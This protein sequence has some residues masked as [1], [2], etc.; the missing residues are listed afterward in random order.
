MASTDPLSIV[1]LSRAIS[2]LTEDFFNESNK[3][4]YENYIGLEK[5]ISEFLRLK[6]PKASEILEPAPGPGL[7]A[8]RLQTKGFARIDALENC[9]ENIKRLAKTG[10]YRTLIPRPVSRLNSTG[11]KDDIYDVVAMV[12]GFNPEK[13]YPKAI[14]ELLRITKPD[15]HILWT[16]RADLHAHQ[17][18]YS[19]LDE[20]LASLEK[21]G[22]CV[23]VKMAEK[24][25]DLHS[26]LQGLLYV[27]RRVDNEDFAMEIPATIPSLVVDSVKDDSV[28]DLLQ[29]Q[30]FEEWSD[31]SEEDLVMVGQYT[32]H[33]KLCKAFL[34]LNLPRKVE[35]LDVSSHSS[36]P[37]LVGMEL[38]HHGYINVDGVDHKL[39]ALNQIRRK[40]RI[41]RN[42]ILGRVGDLGSIPVN[43]ESYDVILMAGGFA[44]G[45]IMPTSFQEILRVLRPGGVIMWTM[46]DGFAVQSQ[47][48][49]LFDV[50][51]KDLVLERKW[52]ILVGPITFKNFALHHNGRFYML[53]KCHREVFA[54]GSCRHSSPS[55]SPRTNRR[56]SSLQFS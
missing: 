27:I 29:Q 41:Y 36:S 12:G 19:L 23:A 44:P 43:D 25:K 46:R 24:F 55:S 15:G 30:S 17:T 28:V 32:G 5:L 33:S 42:Y 14:N 7:L 40:G 56:R 45:K 34:K 31:R 51:V 1:N 3:N 4:Q 48:F 49:A 13:I 6:I 38:A 9:P 47:D 53:R 10:I 26:G 8:A 2:H 11:L 21:Q 54:L 18:E 39:N 16:I 22:K 35:I 50:K 37:G 52:E 20:N